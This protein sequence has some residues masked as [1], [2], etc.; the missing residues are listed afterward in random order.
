[1]EAA[2]RRFVRFGTPFIRLFAGIVCL[3]AAPVGT[4]ASPAVELIPVGAIMGLRL[5][6]EQSPRAR[7]PAESGK[8]PA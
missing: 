3:A 5:V 8:M 2:F 6:L 1:M 4:A 7:H